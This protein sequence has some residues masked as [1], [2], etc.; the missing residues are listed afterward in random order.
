MPYCPFTVFPPS[1]LRLS[2]SFLDVDRWIEYFQ[3][4]LNEGELEEE[5]NCTAWNMLDVTEDEI[6]ADLQKTVT[7]SLENVRQRRSEFIESRQ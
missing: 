4:L 7:G 2:H 6:V 3:K 5:N 1:S